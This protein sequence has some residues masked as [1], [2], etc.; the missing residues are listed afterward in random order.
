MRKV[1]V[2]EGAGSHFPLLIALAS[3]G[4]SFKDIAPVYLPHRAAADRRSLSGGRAAAANGGHAERENLTAGLVRRAK[5][6]ASQHGFP[7]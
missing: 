7:V 3:A 4:L 6:F 1:A 2:T 5:F